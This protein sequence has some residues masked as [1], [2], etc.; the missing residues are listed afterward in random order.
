MFQKFVTILILGCLLIYM[1]GYH[2]VY[3]VYRAGIK[4][5]MR[6]YL[7]NHADTKMGE[8][9]SFRVWNS[10][11]QAKGFDWEETDH[12]FSYQGSMYD[13]VNIRYTAD[14]VYICALPDNREN[15]LADQLATLHKS[16]MDHHAASLSLIKMF[17]VF[18]QTFPDQSTSYPLFCA[19]HNCYPGINICR[20]GA[21]VQTPPPRTTV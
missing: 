6:A 19:V 15:N 5:D 4:Q 2:L 18:T 10:N 12:E 3:G 20:I 8:Y 1:G 14:S 9:L 16:S 7:K 21:E 17:S 13:V 11:I